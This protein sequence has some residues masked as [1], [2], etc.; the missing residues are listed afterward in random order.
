MT[1]HKC[2]RYSIGYVCMRCAGKKRNKG[3]KKPLYKALDML[4]EKQDE[5]RSEAIRDSECKAC[6]KEV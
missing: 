6:L 2:G 5:R 4:K 1:C 3:E